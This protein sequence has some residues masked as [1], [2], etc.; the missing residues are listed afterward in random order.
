MKN[1][2]ALGTV[3]FGLDYGINN[4]GGKV[5]VED[6]KKI[7][8]QAKDAGISVIDTAQTY[9]NSEEILGNIGVQEFD[10]ITKIT[11]PKEGTLKNE[12]LFSLQRLNISSLYGVLVHNFNHWHSNPDSWNELGRIKQ[13]GVIKKIGFSLYH[14][15]QWHLIQEKGIT[16]DLLQIPM[17]L[18]NQQF[19][20]YLSQFKKA[21]IEVHVRSAFLQ[22]LLLMDTE[23]IPLQ[24]LEIKSKIE[25]L[26]QLSEKW[27][28]SRINICLLW[29]WQNSCIDHIVVGIDSIMQWRQNL[30]AAQWCEKNFNT[31]K[32][33]ASVFMCENENIINPSKWKN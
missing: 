29:L 16:P 6:V 26:H 31:L 33:D 24:F 8:E 32:I 30:N 15:E 2:L 7:V 5:P 23:S 10:V 22:G 14:P 13:D 19:R 12:I 4:A 1:K 9:G 20:P 21:G 18:F 25:L 17:N 3:Q 28:V 11:S 27:N